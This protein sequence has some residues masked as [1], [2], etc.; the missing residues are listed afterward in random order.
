LSVVQLV[1]SITPYTQIL[2][3]PLPTGTRLRLRPNNGE[4]TTT[5]PS[6][7]MS[8]PNESL[9][10]EATEVEQE[11]G[12][13]GLQ[14]RNA[15]GRAGRLSAAGGRASRH[16]TPAISP[17]SLLV[18]SFFFLTLHSIPKSDRIDNQ[19]K[20]ESSP[21]SPGQKSLVLLSRDQNRFDKKFSF[22]RLRFA[23][24]VCR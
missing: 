9:L 11:R 6:E 22:N 2:A 20:S 13:T 14:G 24:P 5:T 21:P 12:Q 17:L 8:T 23:V 4:V 3:P 19:K 7:E 15:G 10:E 16:A 18:P 1:L